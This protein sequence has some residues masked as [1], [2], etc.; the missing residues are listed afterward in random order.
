MAVT[1][2]CLRNNDKKRACRLTSTFV[3]IFYLW[4]VE[5][6]AVEPVDAGDNYRSDVPVETAWVRSLGFLVLDLTISMK[7]RTHRSLAMLNPVFKK[8]KMGNYH[9]L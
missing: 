7:L 5:C 4:S 3:S 2:Y 9:L 6:V 1:L 8:E